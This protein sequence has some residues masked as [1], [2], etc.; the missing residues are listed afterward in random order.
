VDG[1]KLDDNYGHVTIRFKICDKR[2]TH[3]V[4]GKYIIY[5]NAEGEKDDEHMDNL[6]SGA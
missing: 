3:P 2:A 5:T 6:Q 1:A 4:T